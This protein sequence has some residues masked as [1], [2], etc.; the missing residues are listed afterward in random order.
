MDL[1]KENYVNI[2]GSN[3]LCLKI[4]IGILTIGTGRLNFI[5]G[6][7]GRYNWI[8]GSWYV[9]F[10]HAGK[11]Q[12]AVLSQIRVISAKRLFRKIGQIDDEDFKRIRYGFHELY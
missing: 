4:N 8:Y 7:K 11:N 12:T 6:L 3:F 1:A 10:R 2:N 5:N 9:R